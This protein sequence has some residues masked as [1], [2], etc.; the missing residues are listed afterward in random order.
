MSPGWPTVSEW[1]ANPEPTGSQRGHKPAGPQ[2]CGAGGTGGPHPAAGLRRGP[3]TCRR[4]RSKMWG[5]TQGVW[6]F[7]TERP[8]G[9]SCRL[10][11]DQSSSATWVLQRWQ[12][13][14]SGTALALQ[15]LWWAIW[16]VTVLHLGPLAFIIS[17]KLQHEEL[18]SPSMLHF[19]I[20]IFTKSDLQA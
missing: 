19:Y 7:P 8:Q 12:S 3:E 15:D 6:V 18:P 2:G 11:A 16:V 20:S 4:G 1:M 5:W 13:R 14:G 17:I 10:Q 9:V